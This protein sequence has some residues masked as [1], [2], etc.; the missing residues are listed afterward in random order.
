MCTR[1][2][3]WQ[4]HEGNTIR[5]LGNNPACS[6]INSVSFSQPV[7]QR[8]RQS[9]PCPREETA[10]KGEVTETKKLDG[11]TVKANDRKWL[12]LKWPRWPSLWVHPATIQTLEKC[13]YQRWSG[14]GVG[15]GGGWGRGRVGEGERTLA[16]WL[17]S[18]HLIWLYL[19][20]EPQKEGRGCLMS[21]SCLKHRGCHLILLSY[22]FAFLPHLILLFF[23]S[24]RCSV[25]PRISSSLVVVLYV[26]AFL[27]HLI[28]WLFQSCCCSANGPISWS[29]FRTFSNILL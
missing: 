17:F 28:L 24:C 9:A 27:P 1:V 6:W 21:I 26:L 19:T 25:R 11:I 16:A 14:G 13:R 20:S 29:F 2:K 5:T 23:Q 12:W 3:D 15:V 4:L 10:P 7:K 8:W 18:Y 22:V